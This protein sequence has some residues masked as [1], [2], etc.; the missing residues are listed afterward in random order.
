MV[1]GFFTR[2]WASFGP[3]ARVRDWAAHAR[4]A[5]RAA[6][7][8]P[9]LAHWHV[10]AGTW[11]VGVDALDNDDRGRIGGSGPLS[12]PA[13]DFI[14]T[15]L[16][17]VP[18]LHRAQLSVVWPGYPRPREGESAGAF[19]YR[20]RR[21]A[22]HLDGLKPHGPDRRRRIAEPHAFILGL[23]L[24]ETSADAA[25]LVVWEG[26]HEIL[27]AALRQALAGR[28]PK[29]WGRVD[30]T[31]AYQAARQRVF[32]TCRRVTLH[33]R[34]GEA[35]LVH[36]LALHGVAPWTV[37]AEAPEEGRMIAYFRPLMPGGVTDWLGAR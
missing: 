27:R 17:P 4:T 34:P 21:D 28:D 7:D 35:Y 3:D 24:T 2:G 1:D 32:E 26:S 33:A 10:C 25:P 15:Q 20:R 12:G 11:F 31:A 23:P 14:E 22:A 30:V 19:R 9:A 16:G 5:G 36:R 6:L 13:L 29:D 18:P 37:G 8:D